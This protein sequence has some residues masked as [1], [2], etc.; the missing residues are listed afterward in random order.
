MKPELELALDEETIRQQIC[1]G[2]IWEELRTQFNTYFSELDVIAAL[3]H[4]FLIEQKHYGNKVVLPHFSLEEDIVPITKIAYGTRNFYSTFAEA[5]MN[6]SIPI[7]VNNAI[8]EIFTNDDFKKI[9]EFFIEQPSYEDIK[10][11]F[12]SSL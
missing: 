3:S 5:V 8:T 10:K 4:Y 11:A 7:T 2:P 9:R 1:K 6:Q 12:I